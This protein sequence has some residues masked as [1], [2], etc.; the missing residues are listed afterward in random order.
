MKAD[1]IY[2]TSA[3]TRSLA[4]GASLTERH[5]KT[6]IPRQAD[7][8]LIAGSRSQFFEGAYAIQ[9]AFQFPSPT[10]SRLRLEG[11]YLYIVRRMTNAY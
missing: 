8:F 1:V 4:S 6:K 5:R 7:A 10:R 3:E 2:R 11:D 9:A